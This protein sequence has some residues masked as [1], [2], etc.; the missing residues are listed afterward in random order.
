MT[1]RGAQA[2][3]TVGDLRL[4]DEVHLGRSYQSHY[5]TRLH[6]GLGNEKGAAQVEVRW[7][8]GATEIFRGLEVDRLHV[9]TEG[10]GHQPGD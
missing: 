2:R 1:L 8:G 6:F 3:V 4:I 9:L 7:I 10:A 5:G